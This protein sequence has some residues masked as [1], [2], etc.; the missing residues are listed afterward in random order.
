MPQPSRQVIRI[1][2]LKM[3][4]SHCKE[5][6]KLANLEYALLKT[7]IKQQEKRREDLIGEYCALAA[8]S[9]GQT[10]SLFDI[11]KDICREGFGIGVLKEK[12]E[13][14]RR[15]IAMYRMRKNV[16]RIQLV[17]AQGRLR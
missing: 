5:S 9:N 11:E 16:S 14:T 15:F 12:L 8:H 3:I 13:A 17:M 6:E 2:S 10:P 4:I 1:T 7:Q